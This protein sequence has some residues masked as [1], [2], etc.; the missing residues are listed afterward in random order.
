MDEG[1]AELMSRIWAGF[2]QGDPPRAVDRRTQ[3]AISAY[4]EGLGTESRESKTFRGLARI[5]AKPGDSPRLLAEQLQRVVTDRCWDPDAVLEAAAVCVSPL[6]VPKALMLRNVYAT[7]LGEHRYRVDDLRKRQRS[8]LLALAANTPEETP[9]M[10]ILRWRL[11]IEKG[12]W[13]QRPTSPD[14]GAPHRDAFSY[15]NVPPGAERVSIADMGARAI[16][17]ARRWPDLDLPVVAGGTYSTIRHSWRRDRVPYVVE[18]VPQGTQAESLQQELGRDPGVSVR[19]LD[20]K[21]R[22]V[23]KV[24]LVDY[25]D[26]QEVIAEANAPPGHRDKRVVRTWCTN[27]IDGE[28]DA[29]SVVSALRLGYLRFDLQSTYRRLREQY[30]LNDY[31]GISYDGWHRHAALVALAHTTEVYGEALARS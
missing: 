17:D 4:I 13:G 2:R 8:M 19:N 20:L 18:W 6:L 10:L 14:D 12:V 15:F 3:R 23:H 24:L 25:G 21:I 31:R 16:A 11:A 5:L 22:S 28:P 27:M 9:T 7:R 26:Q 29:S 1:L 30:G